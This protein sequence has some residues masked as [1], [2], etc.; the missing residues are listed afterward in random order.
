MY[1]ANERLILGTRPRLYLMLALWDMVLIL[2]EV[3]LLAMSEAHTLL[4]SV[5]GEHLFYLLLLRG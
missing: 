4:S 2:M 5:G 1:I 3:Y